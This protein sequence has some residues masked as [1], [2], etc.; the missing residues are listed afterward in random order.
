MVLS[1]SWFPNNLGW[2]PILEEYEMAPDLNPWT[3]YG[4]R[5]S[6]LPRFSSCPG[7]EADSGDSGPSRSCG[8]LGDPTKA[9]KLNHNANERDRRKR[10]NI[11]YSSLRSL[12]PTKDHHSVLNNFDLVSHNIYAINMIVVCKLTC[13]CVCVMKILI[14]RS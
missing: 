10:L 8:D 13:M 11:L 6:D 4:S 1:P 9:K 5:E 12:L 2:P 7:L 14:R 3:H